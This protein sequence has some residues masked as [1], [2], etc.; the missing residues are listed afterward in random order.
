[1]NKEKLFSLMPTEVVKE[2]DV[3]KKIEEQREIIKAGKSFVSQLSINRYLYKK[4]VDFDVDE[5]LNLFSVLCDYDF[6]YSENGLYFSDLDIGTFAFVLEEF[7]NL[8]HE[9]MY[10]L[11]NL[12]IEN[13]LKGKDITKE[14]LTL[15]EDKTMS[16][17]EIL[18]EFVFHTGGMSIGDTPNLMHMLIVKK[19]LLGSYLSERN[20]ESLLNNQREIYNISIL[21]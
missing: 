17:E 6:V 5:R 14:V 9:K 8:E 7:F 11:D 3:N 13:L 18:G 10:E 19:A 2:D 16:F 4:L 20:V 21:M 12:Y 15:W 1:M